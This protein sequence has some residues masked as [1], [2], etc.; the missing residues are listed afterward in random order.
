MVA[1]GAGRRSPQILHVATDT[2]GS[3]VRNRIVVGDGVE[4][5]RRVR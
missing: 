5:N 1:K 3:Y 4:A 2:G